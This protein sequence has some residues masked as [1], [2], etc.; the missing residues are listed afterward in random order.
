MTRFDNSRRAFCH[1][2]VVTMYRRATIGEK[3]RFFVSQ[4]YSTRSLRVTQSRNIVMI[5]SARK[6]LWFRNVKN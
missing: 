5:F 2:S 3:S 4:L 6:L 1:C